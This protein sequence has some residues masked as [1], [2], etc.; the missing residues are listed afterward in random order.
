MAIEPYPILTVLCLSVCPLSLSLFLSVCVCVC[1]C[2]CVHLIYFSLS[3]SFETQFVYIMHL[4]F[5]NLF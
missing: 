1:V 2:V 5:Y 4:I 3:G